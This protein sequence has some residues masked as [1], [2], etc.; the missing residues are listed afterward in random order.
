[1]I[2]EKRVNN[3]L[4]KSL[5][6]YMYVAGRKGG[7]VE[8]LG[9]IENISKRGMG[10]VI[11]DK[12]QI[13]KL[14]T[15]IDTNMQV[16]LQTVDEFVVSAY[17]QEVIMEKFRLVWFNYKEDKLR[18]GFELDN[19]NWKWLNYVVNTPEFKETEQGEKEQIDVM[20]TLVK[21]YGKDSLISYTDNLVGFENIFEEKD[22][23]AI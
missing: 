20:S 21:E 7:L 22:G 17:R 14:M 2:N 6:A 19:E 8:I 9:E 15:I 18:M 10:F 11:T 5:P 23:L 3:R 13:Q 4:N 1:M 12:E 16:I